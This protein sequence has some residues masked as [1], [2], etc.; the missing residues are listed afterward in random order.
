MAV[1]AQP[2][3]TEDLDVFVEPTLENA[4]RLRRAL[5]AFGFGSVA[6][7]ALDLAR[8]DRVFMLGRKPRR[9][10]V[11][12][13][14]SGVSF[15]RA[16]RGRVWISVAGARVPVI[17]RAALLANKVASGRGKDHFDIELLSAAPQQRRRRRSSR[18]GARPG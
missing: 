5:V 17:G 13:G 12:T 1:H 2:R 6:P 18:R 11:L 7:R 14:I 4:R 3:F 15:A 8:P 9:I 10:D 16:S